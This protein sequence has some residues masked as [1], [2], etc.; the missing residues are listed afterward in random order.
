[1]EALV[2]V[3]D[4]KGMGARNPWSLTKYSANWCGPCKTITPMVK[5]LCEEKSIPLTEVD[6][7]GLSCEERSRLDLKTIPTF[8]LN[9]IDGRTFRR[10]GTCPEKEFREWLN[11]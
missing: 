5:K 9:H 3:E 8:D 1:M 2:L 10:T 7:D 11:Q 4:N 6:I